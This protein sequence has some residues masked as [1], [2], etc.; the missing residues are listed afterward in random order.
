LQ[1]FNAMK[2]KFDIEIP[3]LDDTFYELEEFLKSINV[4]QFEKLEDAAKK[5]LV[6]KL[7]K[8]NKEQILVEKKIILIESEL[9][10]QTTENEL[11]E[12]RKHP[13]P[14]NQIFHSR[15][16]HEFSENCI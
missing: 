13:F 1:R 2:T 16:I 10:A 5:A 11:T 4:N 9:S 3:K 7:Q 14:P 8:H 15:L 12:N 6:E